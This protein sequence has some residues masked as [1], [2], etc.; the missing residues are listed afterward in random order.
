VE[1]TPH[2]TLR[3]LSHPVSV[4]SDDHAILADLGVPV[5]FREGEAQI[6][7]TILI[8]G[9]V[10]PGSGGADHVQAL[11]RFGSVDGIS[12]QG[13]SLMMSAVSASASAVTW[14]SGCRGCQNIVTRATAKIAFPK[15]TE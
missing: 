15:V 10:L 14:R 3:G 1:S 5:L 11:H 6:P 7:G 13:Q 4:V 8:G 2:V 12:L 9:G